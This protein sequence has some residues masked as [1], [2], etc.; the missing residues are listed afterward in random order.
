MPR[1]LDWHDLSKTTAS[2]MSIVE[3]RLRLPKTDVVLRQQLTAPF[4]PNIPAQDLWTVRCTGLNLQERPFKAANAE[5]AKAQALA[6]LDAH[7]KELSETVA[8]CSDA[9]ARA[10]AIKTK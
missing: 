5:K 8:A 1:R 6:I 10:Q 7:L 3:F 2:G 9:V 4:D